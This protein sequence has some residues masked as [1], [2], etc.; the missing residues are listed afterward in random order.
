MAIKSKRRAFV[1]RGREKE[2]ESENENENEM[3]WFSFLPNSGNEMKGIKERVKGHQSQPK[4]GPACTVGVYVA[5][6]WIVCFGFVNFN[7]KVGVINLELRR[8]RVF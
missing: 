6:I 2:K 5:S 7:F 8:A 1:E 4:G 3:K